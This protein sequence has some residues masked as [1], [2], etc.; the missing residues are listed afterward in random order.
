M[1][2]FWNL[3]QWPKFNYPFRCEVCERPFTDPSNLRQHMLIH[4]GILLFQLLICILSLLIIA[5]LGVKKF[6]CPQCGMM[7]RQKS[8][9]ESHVNLHD[10]VK[11][12]VCTYC[13]KA[14]NRKY[15]RVLLCVKKL[16]MSGIFL[17]F[18]KS[19]QHSSYE[20]NYV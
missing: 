19:Y 8:H 10:N 5:Y 16:I 9:L 2:N 1:L 7:F 6:K 15:V 13:S 11:N 20:T 17:G 4:E 3:K 12:F 14:F 18:E